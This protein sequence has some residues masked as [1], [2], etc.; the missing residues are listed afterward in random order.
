MTRC[1]DMYAL[2]VHF[3]KQNVMTLTAWTP[4]EWVVN[5][6]KRAAQMFKF[7]KPDDKFILFGSGSEHTDSGIVVMRGG[8]PVTLGK[9]TSLRMFKNWMS[10]YFFEAWKIVGVQFSFPP[11]P[12]LEEMKQL[13]T[14]YIET[15]TSERRI[16]VKFGSKL[17]FKVS[18]PLY[19]GRNV[20][21]IRITEPDDDALAEWVPYNGS[22][23]LSGTAFLSVDDFRSTLFMLLTV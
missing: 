2:V 20:T 13:V 11:D 10:R 17:I 6:E 22:E 8:T 23:A 9:F 19:A 4:C 21:S 15:L 7:E 1:R 14:L 5:G 18:P 3:A 12:T 16:I